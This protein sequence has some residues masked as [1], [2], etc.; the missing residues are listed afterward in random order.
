MGALFA[1][2]AIWALAEA[3]LFFVVADVPIMILG[4]RF[5][6]YRALQAAA[7]AT[8]FAGIGGVVTYLWAESDPQGSLAAMLALPGIDRELYEAAA[9]QWRSEGVMGMTKGSF[10][11]V[12]Y[13][14]YAHA[15]AVKGSSLAFFAAASISARLPRFLAVAMVAGAAGPLLRAKLGERIFWAVFALCWTVFYVWYWNAMGA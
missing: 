13:K 6:R 10:S 3:V 14:L 8:V 1:L 7:L 11:G 2:V 9:E 12:P 15:A 5:G 4:A